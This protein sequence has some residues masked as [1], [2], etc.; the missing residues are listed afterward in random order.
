[1][2]KHLLKRLRQIATRI[3]SAA[4]IRFVNMASVSQPNAGLT[5]NVSLGKNVSGDA[6]SVIRGLTAADKIQIASVVT[7]AGLA[8][9]SAGS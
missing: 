3:I 9:A 6:V 4:T 5:I 2:L 1:M 7:A 8:T